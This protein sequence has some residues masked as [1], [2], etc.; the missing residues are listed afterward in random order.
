MNFTDDEV[1]WIS[2]LL[3]ESRSKL[4]TE[5]PEAKL[6]EEKIHQKSHQIVAKRARS[7]I[8]PGDWS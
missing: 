8:T 1:L 7:V 4:I 3:Y 5:F 2:S 6:I